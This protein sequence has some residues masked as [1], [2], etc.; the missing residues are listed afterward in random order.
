MYTA[1][2]R[3]EPFL[4]PLCFALS[5]TMCVCSAEIGTTSK[6]TLFGCLTNH[7][8][9]SAKIGTTSKSTLYSSPTD[10]VCC[11]AD[12]GPLLYIYIDYN[13]LILPFYYFQNFGDKPIEYSDR[14]KLLYT[15]ATIMEIQ[16]LASIGKIRHLENQRLESIDNS[17]NYGDSFM[18]YRT[19]SSFIFFMAVTTSSTIADKEHPKWDHLQVILFPA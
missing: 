16:R 5:Q 19:S 18:V 12:M 1:L 13:H 7:V 17:R 2:L 3:Q 10:H 8:A 4:R 6:S 15:E 9:F 11:T 14:S